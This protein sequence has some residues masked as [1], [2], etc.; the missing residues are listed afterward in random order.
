MNISLD[1]YND[2]QQATACELI[3]KFWLAHNNF[4]QSDEDSLQDLKN[5]T[6]EGHRFYFITAN[7][8]ADNTSSPDISTEAAENSNAQLSNA[9]TST[10]QP[11]GNENSTTQDEVSAPQI[12]G[13]V[14]LGNRGAE[15]DWLE[16]L[17]V[18]PE[19][20]SKG[21]GRQ[22]IA[23]VE[24]IVK[25]YSESVFIEAAARNLRAIALY[26][27]LGYDCL[28]TITVRKDFD[29]SHLET[30]QKEHIAGHE[31]DVRRWTD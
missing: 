2:A 5:W 22:A 21:I 26:R 17:F 24:N 16:D 27:E 4:E 25:E 12:V 23:L 14:H 30:I 10:T 1:L 29:T 6:A 28:N 3:K 15:I 31:F 18:L 9:K 13:F 11:S 7:D 19:L 8:L 20:Q